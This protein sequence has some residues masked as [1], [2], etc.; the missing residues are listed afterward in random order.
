MLRFPRPFARTEM[1]KPEG[2]EDSIRPVGEDHRIRLVGDSHRRIAGRR[3]VV[4]LQSESRKR[5]VDCQ[6][7]LYYFGH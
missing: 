1:D 7:M 5:K 4:C 3:V 2:E 6:F